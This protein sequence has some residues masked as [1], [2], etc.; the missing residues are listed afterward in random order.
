MGIDAH[1]ALPPLSGTLTVTG[2]Q[3]PV[4]VHRDR[5]GIPHLRADNLAD[6]FF[7]QGF[8]TAQD[9]LFQ[10]EY[11]RLRVEGRVA[12]LVGAAAL[13]WDRFARRARLSAAAR[14][15]YAALDR[16]TRSVLDA[17]T[18]GVNAFLATCPAR[19]VELQELGHEP[20]AWEPWHPVG[21]FVVR[22]ILF[23]SL[24]VKLFRARAVALLGPQ[25]LEWF[26]QEGPA[27]SQRT[28]IVPPQALETLRALPLAQWSA[29]MD[30][31]TALPDAL[32]A[33]G[34]NSWAVSGARTASGLPML[35]GDPHRM[36][37]VP[38]VYAQVHLACPEFDAVGLAFPGIPGV[39]HFGRTRDVAWCV[40]NAQA[41]YQDL[42]IERFRDD[43]GRLL[44]ETA[45]GWMPAQVERE[46]ITVRDDASCVVDTVTTPHGPVIIGDPSRGTALALRSTGLLEAGG[47]LGTVLPLLRARTAADA[48]AALKQWIEPANNFLLADRDGNILY[49][50]AGRIP[51]R[52]EVNA[53]VPVPG[54]DGRHEWAGII[55][56]A[57]LPQCGNPEG[58]VLVTAN[59]RIVDDSYPHILGVDYFNGHR[60]RRLAARLEAMRAATTADLGAVHRDVVNSSA[61][62]LCERL[63]GID[64]APLSEA[65][66]A[67]RDRL[68]SWDGRM[69]RTAEEPA[70]YAELRAQ[71][72]RWIVDHPRF[73]AL[74][75]SAFADEPQPVW[76]LELRVGMALHTL[77]AQD[78]GHVFDDTTDWSTVLGEALDRA[79]GV[80]AAS[81]ERHWGARHRAMPAHP[82][83]G[84][85]AEL[86]ALLAVPAPELDGDLDC[87]FSTA[88]PS[89]LFDHVLV[90]S[91]ARYVFDFAG[92]SA[93]V[94]PLGASGHPASPHFTDQQAAWAEGRLL[95]ICVDWEVIA[96]E[97]E[98]TQ[99]LVPAGGSQCGM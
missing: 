5:W 84:W 87:V 33:A 93:W 10:I 49:R 95:P 70:A 64:P 27:A 14:A 63:R 15:G 81:T 8:T 36:L 47:A 21:V 98:A 45:T 78:A 38:N 66:R 89:G 17:Y 75:A 46:Q 18:A 16:D 52:P 20:R 97:A 37:E 88:G 53:W 40:T 67:L 51:V 77:L 85:S 12:G 28:L 23:A 79:A 65:A 24:G 83:R 41:D 39:Q 29:E 44:V 99:H 72:I 19:P 96:R 4:T 73:A 62:G 22:H 30:A 80:L 34:S 1:A 74:R 69:L 32:G 11:D 90:A 94:V 82:V 68:I 13:G 55:P 2:V 58:G 25:A 61:L 35:A 91:T 56:D 60:A 54:W 26:R 42:F 92:G 3:E 9:R 76:P 71:L 57:E 43:G 6:L 50:T 59:Q 48:A 86:D 31:L 7:A